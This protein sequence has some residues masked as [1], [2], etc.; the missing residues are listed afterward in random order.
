VGKEGRKAAEAGENVM[1]MGEFQWVVVI[2][3]ALLLFA[4]WHIGSVLESIRN[5]VEEIVEHLTGEEE[6]DDEPL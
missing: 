3:L 5:K 2:G 4:T 6:E 1:S